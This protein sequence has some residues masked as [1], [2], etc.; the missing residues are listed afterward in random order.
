MKR[1]LKIFYLSLVIISSKICSE[2]LPLW[3][4]NIGLTGMQL[5]HY[6]GSD[7]YTTRAIPFP[8]FIYRGEWFKASDGKVQGLFYS[9]EDLVID[10]SLSGSLPASADDNNVR[11]GMP[12]LDAT[13]EIGPSM[14]KQLW[15]S[16]DNNTSLSLEVPMRAA[17]SLNTDNWAI[18]NHGWT[19]A[20]FLNL[21][22]KHN[23]WD[24]NFSLGPIYA[25]QRYHSYF[26]D[27]QPQYQT[28]ERT[29]YTSESGY[30]GSRLTLSINK[31]YKKYSIK[32]FARY[33]VLSSAVF[34]DSPLIE[35]SNNFSVGF[36]FMW[37]IA[38]S[39]NFVNN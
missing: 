29:A 33:D 18:R 22:H 26:Y 23:S 16:T 4:A 32:G 1:L 10:V 3:E 25:S 19:F 36:V 24:G 30:S 21:Q 34:M 28:L 11:I 38:Q 14:T 9:S 8:S 39:R 20:P 17:F 35:R 6:P 27:V 12:A 7:S 31:D 37:Q 15:N 5:P 13:F 2:E